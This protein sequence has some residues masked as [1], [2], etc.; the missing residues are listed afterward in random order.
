MFLQKG[1]GYSE[2]TT[3]T[4]TSLYYISTDI[5]CLLAGASALWL[6]KRGLTAHSARLITYANCALIT[7][8][9]ILASQ[10]S[11]GYLLLGLLLCVG[12]GALGLFPCYYSFTQEVDATSIGKITGA[13][14]FL[15]WMSTGRCTRTLAS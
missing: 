6:A 12:A 14:S 5:G 3:L 10:V 1:R 7:M 4:F 8:L 2:A 9:T 11:P 15:G 13:L